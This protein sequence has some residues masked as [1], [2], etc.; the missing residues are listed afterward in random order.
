MLPKNERIKYNGLFEQAYA[1]G[2]RL[3]SQNIKIT[4]TKTRTNLAHKMPL[5][6][7]VVAKSFSKKAVIRNQIKRRLRE[8]YRLYRSS[9]EES[10]KKIGL[11][12]IAIKGD[13]N[14]AE[15][16]TYQYSKLKA[17]LEKL[18]QDML[19]KLN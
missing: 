5:L 16:D 15:T 1:K 12:V 14:Q 2:K 9:N 13:F 19:S 7:F 4:F 17:E 11:L 3:H 8:I 10:L 18:L 6:G